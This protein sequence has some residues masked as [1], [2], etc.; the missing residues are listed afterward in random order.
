MACKL[1]INIGG[2]PVSFELAGV[3]SIEEATNKVYEALSEIAEG[4]TDSSN[5]PIK[6][7]VLKAYN[8]I[9]S[10]SVKSEEEVIEEKVIKPEFY[11]NA[12]FYLSDANRDIISS[13]FGQQEIP[14]LRISYDN[15][16]RY[17]Y[18]SAFSNYINIYLTPEDKSNDPGVKAMKDKF[19]IHEIV[20]SILDK[21]FM[22]SNSNIE[23]L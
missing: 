16:F 7:S 22:Y 18:Y 10:M 13:L 12:C 21:N 14:T 4:N 20:H 5:N 11:Q 17:A 6:E 8:T 19:I 23:S 2:T 1:H 15:T 3:N 9:N